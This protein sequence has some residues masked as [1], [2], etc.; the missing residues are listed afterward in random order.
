MFAKHAKFFPVREAFT[1]VAIFYGYLHV[2]RK[3]PGRP[4]M[5]LYV[6]VPYH[7]R[8]LESQDVGGK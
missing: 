6:P 4:A 1:R 2:L 5:L 8:P 7:T 3:D